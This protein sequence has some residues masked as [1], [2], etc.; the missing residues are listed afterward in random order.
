MSAGSEE[1]LRVNGAAEPYLPL[2]LDLLARKG[3]VGRKGV[4]VALNDAVVPASVWE[5]TAL[6]PGD[7]IEIVRPFGGG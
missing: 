4:A 2:L 1:I 7:R 3:V 5:K 6:R